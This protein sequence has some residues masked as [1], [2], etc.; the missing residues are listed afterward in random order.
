[1][2][3]SQNQRLEVALAKLEERV[4]SLQEDMKVL[5][6]NVTQLRATADKWRGGFWVMMALGG[7]V[8]FVAL[9]FVIDFF[10]IF[11]PRGRWGTPF[12]APK[13]DGVPHFWS[14]FGPILVPT[15]RHLGPL[16]CKSWSWM[17][18]WGYAKRKEFAFFT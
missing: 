18:W 14:I 12:L 11:A 2:K 3:M 9:L 16:W 6:T 13:S 17:G 7:V 8:G 10:R 5:K 15:W 4:E 1:M